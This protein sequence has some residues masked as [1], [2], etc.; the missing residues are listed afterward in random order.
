MK[1]SRERWAP[2]S[3]SARTIRKG[4][5]DHERYDRCSLHSG[6]SRKALLLLRETMHDGFYFL[7]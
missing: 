6:L 5:R 4:S 1:G 2:R 7:L 3:E